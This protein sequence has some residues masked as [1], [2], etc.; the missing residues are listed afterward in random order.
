MILTRRHSYKIF[1][2]SRRRYHDSLLDSPDSAASSDDLLWHNPS[3]EEDAEE[4]TT[5][6]RCPSKIRNC[7]GIT[8]RT[9]NSSRFSEHY[10]SRLLQKFP[11]LIEMFYWIITFGFYRLTKIVSQDIFAQTGI[12]E[13]SQNHGLDIL[14]IE[15]KSWLGFLFP[16]KEYSVQQWFMT[17]HQTAL[18]VLNRFYAL[19]HIP[20]T[21]GSAFLSYTVQSCEALLMSLSSFIAWY[22]YA[23]PSYANFATVRRTLTLTNLYAFIMFTLYPC[24]PPRLLPPEY[25]F[26]DSV[27]RDN[28]QS[29]WMSGNYVNSLAA[30]P[31]LHFGYAFVMGCTFIYHSDIFRSLAKED[32]NKSISYKVFYAA[33]GILYPVSILITIV[34]TANHYWL[35]AIVAVFV[36]TLAYV[37]NR[38][39]LVLLPIEDIL[40]WILRVEK[41]V[42]STGK[43]YRK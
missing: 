9:P 5:A 3:K 38:V 19:L 23:A 34:A 25:G 8:I 39:F 40:A 32:L 15:Q 33:L 12:W 13:V 6:C 20:G 36:A 42:P 17:E 22:Y 29:I 43:R 24:M 28:A 37:S 35:D 11:F 2:G 10:H 26:L 16:I 31:S 41:P 30:M 21:V 18:T 4:A 27:R 1:G 7:C 14:K